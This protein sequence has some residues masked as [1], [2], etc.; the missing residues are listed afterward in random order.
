MIVTFFALSPDI[1]PAINVNST[2]SLRFHVYHVRLLTYFDNLRSYSSV[3]ED[4][5]IIVST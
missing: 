2:D 3:P 4:A 5:K 1:L